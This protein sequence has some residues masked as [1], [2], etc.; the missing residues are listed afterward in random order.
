MQNLCIAKDGHRSEGNRV[1]S[2]TALR[3]R[4]MAIDSSFNG[5]LPIAQR[6]LR[7]LFRGAQGTVRINDFDGDLTVDLRLSEH[8]QSRIFWVGYYSREIVL[9]MNRFLRKGM[10][11]VDIGANIGE[12]TMV[13]AKRV[14]SDGLV[15]S[16]EPVDRNLSELT[17]NIHRN[18]LSNVR[19][20]ASGLS[21]REGATQIY[22]SCGQGKNDEEHLGLNSIYA[23]SGD[24]IPIQSIPLTTLDIFLRENPQERV[25]FIKIDIE[26]AELPCLK[27]AEQTIRRF[28]PLLIV[29]V[30]RTSSAAA[31]YDQAEILHFLG[32][33]G[34]RFFRICRKGKLF[35]ME[36]K[37]LSDYQNILCVHSSALENIS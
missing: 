9:V 28:K 37:D 30:Q 10:V 16:F 27:G 32:P 12:I 3:M 15:L 24:G 36:E 14:G 22:Q 11:F 17:K 23:G 13:A 35:A 2:D 29:E 7:R 25:D 18:A 1:K 6:I 21:D 26:G 4:R 8:M 31:G 19:I 34:Y 5:R 20:V 33:L